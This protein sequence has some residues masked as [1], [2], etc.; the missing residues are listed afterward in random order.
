MSLLQHNWL[1]SEIVIDI[2]QKKNWMK[3]WVLLMS[4]MLILPS[5]HAADEL[6]AAD[7][8][9]L[10]DAIA[11]SM[12]D[13]QSWVSV[14]APEDL[15]Q[16]GMTEGPRNKFA[17]QAETASPPFRIG[18]W[19]ILA[20]SAATEQER[21]AFVERIRKVMLDDASPDHTH[22]VEAMT[23]LN[24]PITSEQER[25]AINE[26]AFGPTNV[27]PFAAWRLAE[28]D[29]TRA[30]GIDRL[31]QLLSS[32]DPI[33]RARSADALSHLQINT[34]P[35]RSALQSDLEKEP[36]DSLSRPIVIAALGGPPLRKLAEASSDPSVQYMAIMQL[37]RTGS[38]DDAP[39]LWKS[40]DSPN[41]DV[42]S[43]SAFALLRILDPQKAASQP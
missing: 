24:A 41:L 43:A 36:A 34:E 10:I 22:S 1:G 42:Q 33:C 21:S 3:A 26:I 15:I 9:K 8:Q 12:N 25:S 27:A 13:G 23:K 37:S 5:A 14:H 17:P 31:V 19:R 11:K 20:R 6:T 39:L 35:V 29:E 38:A 30:K 4:L 32:S 18:V 16:L 40:F 28:S 2:R 7:R